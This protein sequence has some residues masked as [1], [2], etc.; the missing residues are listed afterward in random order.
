MLKSE[1]TQVASMPNELRDR[2]SVFMILG[3][4]VKSGFDV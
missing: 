1:A 3:C 4:G 2:G